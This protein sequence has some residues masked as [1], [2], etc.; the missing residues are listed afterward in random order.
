MHVFLLE[1][2][3]YFLTSTISM[4]MDSMKNLIIIVTNIKVFV[5]KSCQQTVQ[6]LYSVHLELV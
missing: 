3:N 6:L 2:I 1:A 4:D 5:I